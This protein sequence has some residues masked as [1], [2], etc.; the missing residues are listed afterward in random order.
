MKHRNWMGNMPVSR[1]SEFSGLKRLIMRSRVPF[2]S[3]RTCLAAHMWSLEGLVK[4][5]QF[6]DWKDE[7]W[8]RIK[9][10]H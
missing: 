2:I 4:L 8:A 1:F 6:V 9:E 3:R 10:M 5:G 7:P